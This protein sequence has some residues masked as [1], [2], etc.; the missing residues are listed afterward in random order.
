MLLLYVWCNK[1][2]FKII[3]IE[4]KWMDYIELK[5]EIIVC[6]EWFWKVKKER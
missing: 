1:L 5:I 6:L 3:I 2:W 4:N